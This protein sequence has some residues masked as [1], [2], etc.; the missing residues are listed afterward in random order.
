MNAK[1]T[2]ASPGR[3]TPVIRYVLVTG[4]FS[5]GTPRSDHAELW[6][7]QIF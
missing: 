1:A 3:R 4:S 7:R 6:H 5:S 2:L